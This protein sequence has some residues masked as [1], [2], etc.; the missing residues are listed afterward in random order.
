MSLSE[1]TLRASS[2][3]SWRNFRKAQWRWSLVNLSP[4]K[5][6]SAWARRRLCSTGELRRT[7]NRPLG[8]SLQR[9]RAATKRAAKDVR[10]QWS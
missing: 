8:S 3:R 6:P 5:G 9:N 10:C 1:A 4:A 2:I 7:R